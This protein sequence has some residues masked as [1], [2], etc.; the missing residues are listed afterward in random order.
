[1]RILDN[2]QNCPRRFS[3]PLDRTTDVEHQSPLPLPAVFDLAVIRI[4]IL[5][6]LLTAGAN[7]E[8]EAEVVHRTLAALPLTT[9]K[10]LVAARR[11]K[12]AV[13]YA[14]QGELGAARYELNLLGRSLA[15]VY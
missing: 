2:Q 9:A 14:N 1:V 7:L 11:L 8:Q 15:H 12:S 4:A 3:A 10:Y 5:Q 6:D 13:A